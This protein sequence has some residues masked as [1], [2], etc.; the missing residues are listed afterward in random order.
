MI[1][2]YYLEIIF[3]LALK[4]YINYNIIIEREFLTRGFSFLVLR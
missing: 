3:L 4:S 1:T 2:G